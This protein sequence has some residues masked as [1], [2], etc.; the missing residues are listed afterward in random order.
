MKEDNIE[1]VL[2][3]GKKEKKEKR[4]GVRIH[5]LAFE[6]DKV[7]KAVLSDMHYC[8]I[9]LGK[10]HIAYLFV[11]SDWAEANNYIDKEYQDTETAMEMA[12]KKLEEKTK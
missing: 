1:A 8:T 3:F 11:P 12:Y 2:T 7:K 9:A 5:Q 10:N 4:V 6:L